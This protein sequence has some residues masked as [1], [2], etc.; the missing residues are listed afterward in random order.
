MR[1]LRFAHVTTFYPPYNFGGDGIVI[2]ALARALARL[3]HEVTVV[4][5]THTY[6]LLGG[7]VR[8]ASTASDDGVKV[9]PL[10]SRFGA[11]TSLV[12]HQT[13]RPLLL[14]RQL[15]ALLSGGRFDVV[16][17]HNVS[18]IGGPGILSYGGNALKLYTAHEHWLVC[19]MHVLWR[20]GR[21]P[22][23][24]RQCVRCALA[25]RRPPQLYRYTG[26][27]R[28]Q[29]N[30]VDRFIA[31]SEF[32][33]AKHLEF[34]FERAMEVIPPFLPEAS[35][36]ADVA[37]GH[38]WQAAGRPYLLFAGRL[39]RMKGLD[40]VI[41]L[42]RPDSPLD[43]LV[44]G[45]GSHGAT[46]RAL[47]SRS[48]RVRF[49]GRVPNE[50]VHELMRGAVAVLVPTVGFE[51]FGF[52]V[53]EA[54]RESVP[55]IVRRRGPL[56]ELVE[57]VGAGFVFETPAEMWSAATRLASD[58]PL[59]ARLGAIGRAAFERTWS[60]RAVMPRYLTLVEDL[61]T[62]RADENAFG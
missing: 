22:C 23:R 32:S 51:T 31:L 9:V 48:P 33:R 20:H 19:P 44:A 1:R 42:F 3:G 6:E 7:R 55:V 57:S 46:L 13:G 12:T 61:L 8:E 39:E 15:E 29:L 21:E 62:S 37:V 30:E 38:N 43:L 4:H 34:G 58:S 25:H 28:R 52:G 16:H 11:L 35:Q 40:D 2:Q 60:E 36:G 18:A 59:R 24:A 27:M 14:H 54:Y 17:F 56:P 47:A 41:P 5:D 10:A 45:E 53:V 26:F 50:Q 49:L